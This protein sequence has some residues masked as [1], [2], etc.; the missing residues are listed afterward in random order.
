MQGSQLGKE[1][2]DEYIRAQLRGTVLPG[3]QDAQG[4]IR[5][6]HDEF[7]DRLNQFHDAQ[8]D[9]LDRLDLLEGVVGYCSLWMSKNWQLA[10]GGFRRLP[11]D[12]QL[13][14]RKGTEL[15]QDGIKLLSKG[16]WRI[17][18]HVTWYA[19]PSGWG[20]SNT[21]AATKIVVIY[22]DTGTVYSEKEHDG[23][24]TPYGAETSAFS[25]TLVIPDDGAFIVQVHAGHPK[26]FHSVY[27]G[28]VHSALSV[29]KWDSGTSNNVLAPTVP[30]GGTLS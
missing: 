7:T 21:P 11:F 13:G 10:G 20:Q 4:G 9:M 17:D 16:L 6:I 30:N 3:W 19:A 26:D 18:A 27:G 8:L 12:S 28:T 5:T 23:V 25:H 29:N 1:V 24:I 22:A 2:N 15:A 14:P